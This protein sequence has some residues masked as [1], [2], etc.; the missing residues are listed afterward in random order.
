MPEIMRA[1][2]ECAIPLARGEVNAQIPCRT[3]LVMS[4]L[5]V[6][7]RHPGQRHNLPPMPPLQA[8]SQRPVNPNHGVF[9]DRHLDAVP[10]AFFLPSVA[11]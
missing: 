11:P 3:G 9:V 5:C 7:G 8:Q 10:V 2:E 4:P 6:L 1:Q